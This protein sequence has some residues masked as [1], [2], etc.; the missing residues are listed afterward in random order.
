[1]LD[2]RTEAESPVALTSGPSPAP[3]PDPL[4]RPEEW[5]RR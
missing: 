5:K 3:R 1:M 2:L 4:I